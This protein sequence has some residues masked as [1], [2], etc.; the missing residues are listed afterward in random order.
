MSFVF[1]PITGELDIVGGSG[2]GSTPLGTLANPFPIYWYTLAGD[3]NTY[4]CSID[5][6][7]PGQPIVTELVVVTLPSFLLETGDYLLLETGDKLLLE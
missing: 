1:N 6:A 2:G 4:R 5:Y 7:S 3:G